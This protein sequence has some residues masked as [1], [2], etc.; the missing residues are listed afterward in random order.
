MIAIQN[1]TRKYGD[2]TAV[3]RVSTTIQRGEIVG[4]LGHNGAGKTTVMKILTGYLDASSGAVTV[5]GHDVATERAAVQERIGYLPENAPLYEDMLV[6]EYLVM[7]AELRAIPAADIGKRVLEAAQ[8]TGIEGRLLSPIGELSKGL[9]QRVGIAQAILHK[10][11]VLVLDEPTNGLDPMQIQAIRDLVKRLGKEST[12]ILSTHILQEVEA[13]C[14][15]VLVMI[16]GQLV[17]DSP[18]SELLDARRLKLVVDAGAQDVMK[19]L[20]A[21]DGVTEVTPLPAEEGGDAW[22]IR[23]FGDKAPVPA[24]LAAAGAAGWTVRAIAPESRTLETVFKELQA[25]HIAAKGGAA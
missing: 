16:Q 17:A 2:T 13:V 22:A 9:R 15:R 25:R 12:I 6:Q 3:D 21:V 1:L 8:A 7:M 4:L 18:L 19:R 10:P 23:W 11:S 14:D 5:D 20:G 24:I